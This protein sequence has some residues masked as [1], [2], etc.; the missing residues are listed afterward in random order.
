MDEQKFVKGG[1]FLIESISPQEVFTP[2]EFSEEQRLIGKAAM[3]FTEGE[4][5]PRSMISKC[6][7]RTPADAS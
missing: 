3:E 2:E 6:R 1:A 7:K 4:V 5:Q